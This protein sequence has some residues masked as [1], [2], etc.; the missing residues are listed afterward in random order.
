MSRPPTSPT[1]KARK[2]SPLQPRSRRSSAQSNA[3]AS[4][5]VTTVRCS[6]RSRSLDGLLDESLDDRSDSRYL[7]KVEESCSASA[8]PPLNLEVDKTDSADR[9]PDENLSESRSYEGNL[10]SD[11]VREGSIMSLPAENK[12][13]KNFM[14][15]CMSRVKNFI[16]K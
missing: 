3:R 10:D 5:F 11:S 15:K 6:N 12:R 2:F 14:D 16:K 4:P 1:N 7:N 9:E 13:K 8:I